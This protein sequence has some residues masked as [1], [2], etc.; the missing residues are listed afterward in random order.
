MD[1]KLRPVVEKFLEPG[2]EVD[3]RPTTR[4]SAS[5]L[6][7]LFAAHA[8]RAVAAAERV[9]GSTRAPLQASTVDAVGP[10]PIIIHKPLLARVAKPWWD[11]SQ[12]MQHDRD[13]QVRTYD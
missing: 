9:V 10:S 8:S 4:L 11:M 7:S 3:E 6:C 13:A 5:S 1:P 2:I 12:R